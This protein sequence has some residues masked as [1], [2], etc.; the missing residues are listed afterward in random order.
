MHSHD[1]DHGH[2]HIG[3]ANERRVF[4]AMVVT[5]LFMGAEF[6]GGLISG[7]L[8]LIADAGHMLT[9]AA[10]LALAWGAF[11]IAR[12]PPDR[13]RS[14]GYDRFQ[15]L[16]AFTNG[17]VLLALVVWILSEA[18]ERILTPA[19]IMATP[20]LVIAVLGLFVNI[21]AFKILSG[22]DQKNLNIQGAMLHIIG[23][24]LGSVAAIAAALVI[25]FT[26]WTPIDPI[27]SILVALLILRSAWHLVKKAA[28]IL[29]EGVP[30]TIDV[31]ELKRDLVAA[32]PGLLD[33]HHIHVW[34]LT[35]ER[36][37]LTMHATVDDHSDAETV[38]AG[39]KARLLAQHGIDHSTIQV[40]SGA[41]ADEV[42]DHR[43]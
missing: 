37:L 7:S 4:W 13:L 9:D 3:A 34:L 19:P 33:A 41:C 8:A 29:M 43:H 5:A 18:F 31:E 28:H 15:V 24:L 39:I 26:G 10:A 2:S 11:R 12:R 21:A 6:A 23:D 14:Y 20:M 35:A 22:G 17:L 38:L 36:P 25:L 42:P 32:V 1:H 16:A 27:L 40:E 30:D